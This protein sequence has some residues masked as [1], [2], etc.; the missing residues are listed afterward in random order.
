[1]RFKMP[2]LAALKRPRRPRRSG[3]LFDGAAPFM[4]IERMRYLESILRDGVFKT[5]F[6]T[7]T[8]GGEWA[9]LCRAQSELSFFDIPASAETARRPKYGY[10]HRH[11]DGRTSPDHDPYLWAHGTEITLR[12]HTAILDKCTFSVGDS[13]DETLCGTEPDLAPLPFRVPGWEAVAANAGD[14]LSYSSLEQLLR[15]VEDTDTLPDS[16]LRYIE[17]QFHGEIT[18]Q[19]IEEVIFH[20]EA[21][22]ED[23]K[24]LLSRRGIPWRLVSV[25]GSAR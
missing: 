14:I 21:P 5:S 11:P 6:E 19:D 2:N 13:L 8:S 24:A 16:P 7:G 12:F 1:M 4:R 22:S 3:S 20:G 17:L 18:T 9:L 15:R 10:L 25:E 23:A